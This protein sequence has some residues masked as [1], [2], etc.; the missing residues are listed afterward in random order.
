MGACARCPPAS[1]QYR[2]HHAKQLSTFVGGLLLKPSSVLR[3]TTEPGSGKTTLLARVPYQ[4]P[5]SH[6]APMTVS[7]IA[8]DQIVNKIAARI[9]P[10]ASN[11]PSSSR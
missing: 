7:Q 2:S 8:I 4:N 1:V 11:S 10:T 6:F 9:S 5:I 3:I